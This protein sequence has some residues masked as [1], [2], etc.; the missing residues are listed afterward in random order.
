MYIVCFRPTVLLCWYIVVNASI[1]RISNDLWTMI[2]TKYY[3]DKSPRPPAE[4]YT[5]AHKKWFSNL[6]NASPAEAVRTKV[7]MKIL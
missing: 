1:M 5:S 2:I 4:E 7:T 3:A 6:G